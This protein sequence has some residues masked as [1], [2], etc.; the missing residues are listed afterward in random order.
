M[1]F[2]IDGKEHRIY[3]E[4]TEKGGSYYCPLCRQPVMRRMGEK[5]I[6]HFAHY[7]VKSSSSYIPCTDGWHYDKSE[8]HICWQKRFPQEC[9]EV[10][11]ENGAKRHIADVLINGTVIEFQHS[12]ISL[13]EFNDRNEFYKQCGYKVVW[14]FDLIEEC[15]EGRI[16]YSADDMMYC[17][18]SPWKLFRNLDLSTEDVAIYFQLSVNDNEP[19]LER[20]VR[21]YNKFGRFLTDLDR[22]LSVPGFVSRAQ[23]APEYL[24]REKCE[25]EITVHCVDGGKTI[26]ELWNKNYSGMIVKNLATEK[27]ML[28][29]SFYG[30]LQHG[31]GVNS[32]KIVGRYARKD[33]R[34]DYYPINSEKYYVVWQAD[35]PVWELVKAFIPKENQKQ[36]IVT[37]TPER[38]ITK[39]K[40]ELEKRQDEPD[41][42][43]A[44]ETA[45]AK[46]LEEIDRHLSET[47]T[48][49]YDTNGVRWI[50]CEKCGLVSTEKDFVSYGGLGRVNLGICNEC[51][52]VLEKEWIKMP[53]EKTD[54]GNKQTD[55]SRICPDCGGELLERSGKF[56]KFVGC[57]NYPR[58]KYK[59]KNF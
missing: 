17:W 22:V 53:T 39:Q 54:T 4:N 9:I 55:Y 15:N 12:L 6:H 31:K 42:R 25:P 14:V 2:A 48:V 45:Q 1:L 35:D 47:D 43:K 8:W 30:N 21:S 56:G 18:S 23:N 51:S 59:R 20:V 58:C 36:D 3:I 28:I 41:E 37:K 11:V 10:I 27:I 32:D 16:E 40:A 29:N 19:C 49:A 34:K 24:Y 26:D 7:P 38:E 50:K 57:I 52:Q 33:P 46:F 44:K 5:R 13:A